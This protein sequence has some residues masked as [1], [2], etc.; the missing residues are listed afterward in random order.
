MRILITGAAGYIG[1]NLGLEARSR[2]FDVSGIDV[3]TNYYSPELKRANE[4]RLLDTGIS[5]A[6]IDLAEAPLEDLLAG[7]DAVVHLAGQPGISKTTPWI[8]YNRNN[9]VATHR[10]IEAARAADVSKF[11]NV[12]SSSVYGIR[13]MDTEVS[14]P[15]P[16]SWYGETKLAA[17]LEAIGAH[18]LSGFPSCSL[19]LF[20][21]YGERE[22]PEKLFPKLIRSIDQDK[23][24]PLYEGSVD[25]QRSFTYVGDICQA[26]LSAL[27]CWDQAVGEIFNVGSDRCFATGEAISL[28]E[29]IMGKKARIKTI[30]ARPGDQKATHAN[31]EKIRSRL[32]WEP[33]TS[34]RDGLRRMVNWYFAE[35]KGRIEWK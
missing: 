35:V 28:V 21:V 1:S 7:S 29:D 10:L 5:I 20:S 2:G 19:R 33:K 14:E 13:A 11:I 15:K 32:E 3:F 4:K 18:R 31:V 27:D 23:E 9:V 22:R 34:L 8:D 30:P 6:N 24:F 12:S 17:E 25:H 16:A 26:I